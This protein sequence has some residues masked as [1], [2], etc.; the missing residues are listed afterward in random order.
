[1]ENPKQA[2][3]DGKKYN[4]TQMLKLTLLAIKDNL[5]LYLNSNLKDSNKLNLN[6]IRN[7]NEHISNILDS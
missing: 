5:Y 6:K 7:M 3:Y 2:K 4:P 1:M